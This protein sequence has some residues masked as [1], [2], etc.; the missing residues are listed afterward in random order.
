MSEHNNEICNCPD[1]PFF[2]VHYPHYCGLPGRR[3]VT[4]GNVRAAVKECHCTRPRL[5]ELYV[6]LGVGE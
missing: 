3:R 6:K 1:C 4:K 5:L 2:S